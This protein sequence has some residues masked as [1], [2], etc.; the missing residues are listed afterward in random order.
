[1]IEFHRNILKWKT[2]A[3][4]KLVIGEKKKTMTMTDHEGLKWTARLVS[5]GLL[6]WNDGSM[7]NIQSP[8]KS[9]LSYVHDTGIKS[10]SVINK[11][12]DYFYPYLEKVP[13]K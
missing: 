11:F 6:R 5:Q 7:W 4:S 2:G 8:G 12:L 3:E 13:M 9:K 1:M 10:R